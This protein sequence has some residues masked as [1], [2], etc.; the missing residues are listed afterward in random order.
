ML[1]TIGECPIIGNKHN[2]QIIYIPSEST[3]Q[4]YKADQWDGQTV[5]TERTEKIDQTEMI[6]L[7]EAC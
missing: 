3:I 2:R 7:E 4:M 6:E 1:K 5:K